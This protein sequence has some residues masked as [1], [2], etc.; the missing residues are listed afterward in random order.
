MQKASPPG[1]TRTKAPTRVLPGFD[2]FLLGYKDRTVQ[3]PAGR[4]DDVVPGG[5]G[6][7]RATLC[8]DGVAAGTWTRR[9]RAGHV[10]IEVSPFAPLGPSALRSVER[11]LAGYAEY[12]GRT[13][14]ISYAV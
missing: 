12:L 10:D 11:S 5:N 8:L 13:V 14:R 6:M 1:A 2:E 9:L 7:F 4:M 3:L